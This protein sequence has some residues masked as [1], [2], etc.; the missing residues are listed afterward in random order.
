MKADQSEI[1]YL[2]GDDFGVVSRSPHLEYFKKHNLEVLYLTDPLDSFML[3]NLS[4]YNGKPLKNIDDAGLDL[5]E[6]KAEDKAEAEE[7]IAEDDFKALISRF[8]E[9]L[10]EQVEDV[11]ESKLLTDSPCRLVNPPDAAN[12]NMQR[13][14]RLLGKEYQIPKKILEINRHSELIQN[15]AARL[16][17]DKTDP[18]LNLLIEQLFASNLVTEGLHPNPAELIP[19]MQEVM[20]AAAKLK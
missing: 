12:A 4:D 7:T 3:I 16:V 18:L 13:V 19:R 17:A 6:E 15:L 9:V 1:Y 11:R 2:I 5:P 10:G 8:K 20:A 14:Q